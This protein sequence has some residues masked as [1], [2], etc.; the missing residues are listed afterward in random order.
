VWVEGGK[1]LSLD[2]GAAMGW[3][4]EGTQVAHV[5]A[6]HPRPASVLLRGPFTPYSHPIHTPHPHRAGTPFTPHHTTKRH[7]WVLH[8]PPPIAHSRSLYTPIASVSDPTCTPF[9]IHLHPTTGR[10][11]LWPRGDDNGG[12]A[13][14]L[15]AEVSAAAVSERS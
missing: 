15:F 10:T 6:E 3:R 2:R 4:Y 14:G 7:T 11:A 9:T 1:I 8:H 13:M 12:T 5:G